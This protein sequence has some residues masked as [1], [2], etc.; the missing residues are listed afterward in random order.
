MDDDCLHWEVDAAKKNKK[1]A[2]RSLRVYFMLPLIAGW[3]VWAPC[4][5]A[6]SPSTA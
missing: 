1:V 4:N 5:A 2:D 3:D 6:S